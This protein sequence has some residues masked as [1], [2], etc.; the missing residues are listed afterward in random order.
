LYLRLDRRWKSESD[1]RAITIQREQ[2]GVT[3]H[4]F[5]GIGRSLDKITFMSLTFTVR[6]KASCQGLSSLFLSRSV[7][8]STTVLVLSRSFSS[9]GFGAGSSFLQA[10]PF[11]PCTPSSQSRSFLR[12]YVILENMLVKFLRTFRRGRPPTTSFQKPATV[13]RKSNVGIPRLTAIATK[14][15]REPPYTP[16]PLLPLPLSGKVVSH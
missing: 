9:H 13:S 10:A 14:S 3:V 7:S 15:T 5:I 11:I 6:Q 1:A 8:S 2:Y 16:T 4:L 12:Q